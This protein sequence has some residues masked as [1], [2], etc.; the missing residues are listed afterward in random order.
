MEINSY[1]YTGDPITPKFTLNIGDRVLYDGTDFDV[2]ITDN[3]NV[4]T[5]HVVITG[6]GKFKGVIERT[7]EITPVHARS[8]MYFADVTEFLYTGEPC[9]MKV[10]VKF[11]NT[12]LEEGVDYTVEYINNVEPGTANAVLYFSGNFVGTMTIP[13]NIISAEPEKEDDIPQDIED[14]NP[15]KNTSD[16]SSTDAEVGKKVRIFASAEG[17]EPPY[18]FAVSYKKVFSDN[19]IKVSG[20][21]EKNSFFIIPGRPV[22][23]HILVKAR[24]KKGTVAKKV[25]K[26][27]VADT[28]DNSTAETEN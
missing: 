4:G 13:F 2:E 3:I 1:V 19:W 14:E 11:G 7:F 28:A 8:L 24:D 17:G 16:L 20:F 12:T 6:K 27:N 25:F 15:L 21:S 10:A 5:A 23:Y 9:T 22:R 18:T 26:I